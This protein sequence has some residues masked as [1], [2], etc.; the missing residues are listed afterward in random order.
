MV[1]NHKLTDLNHEMSLS[2]KS[3]G[4]EIKTT[5]AKKHDDETNPALMSPSEN[6]SSSGENSE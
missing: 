2:L 1:H 6:P 5:E 4:Q 3:A